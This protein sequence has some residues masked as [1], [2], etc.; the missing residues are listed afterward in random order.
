[1]FVDHRQK[2]SADK[3]KP[4]STFLKIR[5]SNESIFEMREL[6]FEHQCHSASLFKVIDQ[7]APRHV[8]QAPN[9]L[10]LGFLKKF[11]KQQPCREFANSVCG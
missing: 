1:M 5:N 7:W 6:S 11:T 10:F 4:T 9:F 8:A 2:I 3:G